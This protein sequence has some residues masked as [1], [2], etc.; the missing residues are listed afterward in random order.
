MTNSLVTFCVF[1]TK[2]NELNI[3]QLLANIPWPLVKRLSIVCPQADRGV[4]EAALDESEID[5]TLVDVVS[6]ESFKGYLGVRS[7]VNEFVS[8]ANP[9]KRSTGWY[10]QQYLKIAAV[11]GAEGLVVIVDGDTVLRQSTIESMIFNKLVAVTKESVSIYNAGLGLIGVHPLGSTYPS[12]VANFGLIDSDV[13]R[14]K[15]AEPSEFFGNWLELIKNNKNGDI[16]EYQLFGTL[17]RN[18][19]WGA[20]RI[21]IFRRADLLSIS[22]SSTSEVCRNLLKRYDAV[23]FEHHHSKGVFKKIAAR[24]AAAIGYSW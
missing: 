1:A 8:K 16:S 14:T 18:N 5:L 7:V 22:S 19:G 6:D 17:M 24:A 23:A 4:I 20:R 10:M 11:T 3:G 13:L 12:F 21:N 9:Y 15:C 2:A